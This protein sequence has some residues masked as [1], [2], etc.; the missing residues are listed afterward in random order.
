MSGQHVTAA[1][2][3][4]GADQRYGKRKRPVGIGVYGDL[5]TRAGG[6]NV[7]DVLRSEL[8]TRDGCT[9]A[10]A[11]ARIDP[12]DRHGQLGEIG[13]CERKRR[14]RD[15]AHD[16]EIVMQQVRGMLLIDAIRDTV[17]REQQFQARIERRELQRFSRHPEHHMSQSRGHCPASLRK[18]ASPAMS[19]HAPIAANAIA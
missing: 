3:A 7:F 18:H 1:F 14:K 2:V 17:F 10:H 4:A 13:G 11:A 16:F 6:G 5:M 9:A 19:A 12:F 15:A 8:A